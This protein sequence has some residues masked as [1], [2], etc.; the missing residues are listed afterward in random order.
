[1]SADYI[2]HHIDIYINLGVLHFGRLL[3]TS[4]STLVVEGDPIQIF[5]ADYPIHNVFN[6]ST[7]TYFIPL[8]RYYDSK[9]VPAYT[10]EYTLPFQN[11]ANREQKLWFFFFTTKELWSI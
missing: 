5:P 10:K 8:F 4:I 6:H 1:M 7:W 2:I 3:P 11:K 9:G